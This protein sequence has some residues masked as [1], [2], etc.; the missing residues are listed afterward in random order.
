MLVGHSF[1]GLT[2]MNVLANHTRLFNAYIAIDP[3]MWYDQERFLEATKKKLKAQKYD[4]IKLYMGIA[5]TMPDGMTLEK[6]K[7]DTTTDTRHIRSIFALDQ[8]IKTNSQNGLKYAGKYYADD[9]H[10]S[11]PLVSEYEGLRFI[12][13]YY[14]MKF[15]LNDFTDTTDALA[16]K[17]KKHYETVSKEF[18][19]KVLPPE[20]LINSF[21]Y[22]AL[23][24]KYYTKAAALFEMNITNYPGSGNV[25][26]SY[27][28]YFAARKDTANAMKWYEK[29]LAVKENEETKQKL[30]ALQG[31]AIFKI[32]ELELQKYIGEYVFDGVSVTATFSVKDG[33]LWASVPGQ[34]D[35]ELVPVL[36]NSF[37]IK[38]LEGYKVQFEMNGD[39]PTGLTSTQPNGTFKATLKQ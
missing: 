26:D 2:V 24:G 20:L 34:G 31:L 29:A 13:E 39:K 28:D 3:S 4:G 22:Q 5:N 17:Y 25:Y 33:A 11:V 19:Y 10:G 15:T 21:G 9:D 1:G 30:N 7:K 18:G 8:F 14:R 12:F 16:I 35:F 23:A 38:N 36:Q 6:M 27:G 32:T 37:R